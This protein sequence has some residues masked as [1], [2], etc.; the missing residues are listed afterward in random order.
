VSGP[1]SSVITTE[2]IA[3]WVPAHD[4]VHVSFDGDAVLVHVWGTVNQA[5][6]VESKN[7]PP[8]PALAQAPPG[9]PYPVRYELT[10][11]K[12]QPRRLAPLSVEYVD[13]ITEGVLVPEEQTTVAQILNEES[14]YRLRTV[15]N[16]PTTVDPETAALVAPFFYQDPDHTF[17]VEPTLTEVTV[18][19]WD[20][21]TIPPVTF[22]PDLLTDDYW[23]RQSMTGQVPAPRSTVATASGPLAAVARYSI[24]ER[25]DWLTQPGNTI[26]Y[27]G[28]EVG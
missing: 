15:G 25:T 10:G 23:R 22:R 20:D 6:R 21:W 4:S 24:A 2:V 18:D 19:Q 28:A 13:R 17:H 7:S 14:A 3:S 27:D 9:T 5:F 8:V 12:G 26:R 11:V 16:P 1:L